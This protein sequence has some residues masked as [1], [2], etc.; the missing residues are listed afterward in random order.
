MTCLIL[1]HF[2]LFLL[3]YKAAM[4]TAEGRCLDATHIGQRI[5]TLRL[6]RG[7]TQ[8]QLAELAGT[9]GVHLGRLESG[10]TPSLPL[11]NAIA[12]AL[13][14]SLAALVVRDTQDTECERLRAEAAALLDGLD[15]DRLRLAV[16]ILT[17]FR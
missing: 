10:G 11:L 6:A 15:L 16:R 9:S 12:E 2:T 4:L 1:Q 13:G 14:V 7:Y 8:E 3:P 17:A 5:R